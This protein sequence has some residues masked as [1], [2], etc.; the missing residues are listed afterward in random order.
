MSRSTGWIFCLITSTVELRRAT[1][2]MAGLFSKPSARALISSENVAENSRFWRFGGSTASTFLMSRMKP[3]SSMRSA[4]SRIRISTFD[5]S[6]VP[7]PMWSSKRPGVATR[8]STPCLSCL[9]CGLMPTPPK[10][11]V[12][13]NLVYLL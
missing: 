13:F 6:T 3:M 8:M 2:I 12:E 5:R 9:I 7:W 1:S 10:I 4:S 11:T